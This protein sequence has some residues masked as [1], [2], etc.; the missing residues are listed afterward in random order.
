MRNYFYAAAIL[1]SCTSANATGGNVVGTKTN[2]T[3][4]I[5]VTSPLSSTGGSNPTISLSGV[6]PASNLPSTPGVTYS[7]D[8]NSSPYLVWTDGVN[9]STF[10]STFFI[11]PSTTTP[12]P[13]KAGQ[14]WFDGT[15]YQFSPDGSKIY[16]L[17]MSTAASFSGG[18]VANTSTFQSSVTVQTNLGIASSGG[19]AQP[20]G[21]STMSVIGTL[22]FISSNT[23]LASTSTANS[24]AV[25][26]FS[27]YT[28]PAN[29]LS[30]GDSLEVECM[31]QNDGTAP[32]G[33]VQEI[34]VDY[35]NGLG[36]QG[37]VQDFITT[38]G[39]AIRLIY[40]ITIISA[41]TIWEMPYSDTMKGTSGGGTPNATTAMGAGSNQMQWPYQVANAATFKC[42]AQRTGGG[43]VNFVYMKV[44]KA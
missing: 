35:N 31:Y 9:K 3:V 16:A 43:N 24:V 22:F 29:S 37:R 30:V 42:A 26:S 39:T 23:V 15:E 8:T 34:L 28:L 33:E 44:R 32:S 19:I 40:R 4:T 1:A 6:I 20:P 11:L 5:S 12:S 10:A 38:A 2:A 18:T 13:L 17:T 14:L 41:S 21:G 25:V 36:S 7:T 27:T